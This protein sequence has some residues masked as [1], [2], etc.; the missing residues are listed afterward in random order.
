MNIISNCTMVLLLSQY[1]HTHDIQVLLHIEII[2]VLTMYIKCVFKIY[3]TYK[4]YWNF[5]LK[6]KIF[7][8]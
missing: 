8:N 1:V 2:S 6:E 5:D 4:L 7:L 3:K